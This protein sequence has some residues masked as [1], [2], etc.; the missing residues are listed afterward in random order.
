MRRAASPDP[1]AQRLA[2]TLTAVLRHH[3]ADAECGDACGALRALSGLISHHQLPASCTP[4]HPAQV[5]LPRATARALTSPDQRSHPS[6]AL[7]TTH[8]TS[9]DPKACASTSQP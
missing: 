3:G 5:P 8:D 7:M 4:A 6:G 2:A 9:G 1:A